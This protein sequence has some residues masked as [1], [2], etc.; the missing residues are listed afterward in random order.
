MRPGLTEPG[1]RRTVRVDRQL[2]LLRPVTLGPPKTKA[3]YRTVPLVI[4]DALAAHL[5]EF[6]AGDH[7]LVFT[8]PGGAPVNRNNLTL[9]FRKATVAVGAPKGTR[10]NDL[11][12]Y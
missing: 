7:G 2:L 8:R 1:L 4:V 10:M 9:V 11:R 12:H 5:A 3:S 6:P